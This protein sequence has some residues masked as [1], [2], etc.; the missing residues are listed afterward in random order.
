METAVQPRSIKNRRR[1]LFSLLKNVKPNHPPIYFND[2]AVVAKTEQ[3][4]FGVILDEQLKF[5]AHLKEI[6][7]KAN[8]GIGVIIFMSDMSPGMFWTR[9][10]NFTFGLIWIMATS[11]TTSMILI[12]V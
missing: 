9:C 5:N 2:E 8:R 7:G 10:I 6:I 4:H 3:K 12:S 11:S 1:K